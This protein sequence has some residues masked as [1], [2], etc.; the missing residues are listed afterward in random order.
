MEQTEEPVQPT[1]EESIFSEEDFSMK[2][3]DKHIRNARITLFII[4]G[5][6]LVAG[7][8]TS[9]NLPEPAIWITIGIY[10]LFATVFASLAFWTRKKPYTALLI[11]LILYSSL[12]VGDGIIDPSSIYKGIFLKVAIIVL[13][14]RGLN[15]GK[16]AQEMMETFGK[17]L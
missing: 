7:V 13:L 4:A 1:P 14:V 3:Y 16:Q 17:G 12:V 6:Q 15:N 2:G 5:V 8:I 9:L 11:A 10:A